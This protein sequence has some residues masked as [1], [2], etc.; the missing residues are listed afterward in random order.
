MAALAGCSSG[1]SSRAVTGAAPGASSSNPNSS[2]PATASLV[3]SMIDGL[4]T[5][6]IE[7][8]DP[9][10]AQPVEQ[11]A[12]PV[13]PLKV[14]RLQVESMA[15]EATGRAGSLG[16]ELDALDAGS[17][18]VHTPSAI[19]AAYVAGAHTAGADWARTLMG[20]QD[21]H[22]PAAL[23]IPTI[24]LVL[25]TSDAAMYLAPSSQDGS[26]TTEQPAASTAAG[27][28]S[29]ALAYRPVAATSGPC[30]AFAG[31]IDDVVGDV[32][33]ALTIPPPRVGDTGS[34]FLNDILQA[35]ANLVVGFLN[36]AIG[37]TV[38]IVVGSV[39]VALKPA[40]DTIAVA[41]GIF[42]IVT[43]VLSTVRRWSVVVAAD[44]P[45]I[46]KSVSPAPGEMDT[47]T[48][49]IDLGGLDHWP[50]EVLA[51]ASLA[52]VTLPELSAAGSKVSWTVS[53]APAD[54]VSVLDQD[55]VVVKGEGGGQAAMHVQSLTESAQ[56]A[57][58]TPIT[59]KVDVSV[60]LRRSQIEDLRTSIRDVILSG[61]FGQ[62]P[63]PLKSLLAPVT[64]AVQ[65]G[66]DDLLD[67]IV[68]IALDEH[69]AGTFGV[70]YHG[71]PQPPAGGGTPYTMVLVAK[72]QPG[73]RQPPP[74]LGGYTCN[75]P[76]GTWRMVLLPGSGA[77]Q[78]AT[79][80]FSG[81]GSEQSA[82]WNVTIEEKG[83]DQQTGDAIDTKAVYSLTFTVHQ[84]AGTPPTMTI[85]GTIVQTVIDTPKNGTA[86]IQGPNTVQAKEFVGGPTPTL[87][88]GL[89]DVALKDHPE[90]QHPLRSESATAC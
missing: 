18:A 85:G 81:L 80:T 20:D 53:Q 32:L 63:G 38:T 48:A 79:L 6:H 83:T 52:D 47:V 45:Q 75:G 34:S 89:P 21:L 9:T 67:E 15:L 86:V 76:A 77:D 84:Q 2:A 69:G 58:G 70:V 54:L 37:A 88:P 28:R 16:S 66:I 71:T 74:A 3:V 57:K 11:V 24:V 43:Q 19:V 36:F 31:I 12:A 64:N 50:A 65:H 30:S 33:K 42:A 10:T 7:V 62:I 60:T 46:S 23:I 17:D 1:S 61:L 87:L 51:C 78:V 41:A 72:A 35:G 14:T 22:H 29:P 73:R 68:T 55:P 82:T 39:K 59:G 5:S 4:A 90:W 49:A 44:F 13:S 26:V 56:L 40:L 25:F 27:L 8:V